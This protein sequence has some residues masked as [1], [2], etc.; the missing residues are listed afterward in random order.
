MKTENI[1]ELVDTYGENYQRDVAIEE[2]SELIK[3]ICKMNRGIGDVSHLV[4][5]MADVMICIEQL[6]YMFGITEE[7]LWGWK[8]RKE[9]RTM[10]RLETFKA[11][12]RKRAHDFVEGQDWRD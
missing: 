8:Q 6:Q 5:E 12:A 10:E 3:E 7:V 4:E 9:K 11:E 1:K 2:C